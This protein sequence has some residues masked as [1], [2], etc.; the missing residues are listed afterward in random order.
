M[1][2]EKKPRLLPLNGKAWRVLRERV[3]SEEPLCRMCGAP[4]TDVDH[5]DNDG[6]NN[7]RDNLQGLC[8]EC[9]SRKTAGDMG[10]RA[11]WGCDADGMP[12]DPR[13]PWAQMVSQLV[14]RKHEKSPATEAQVPTGLPCFNAN[15]SLNP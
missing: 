1:K 15:R 14:A 7:E 5:I 10:K 11:T 6:N 12:L 2:Y 9:H 4:A 13:H 8:H 3:L